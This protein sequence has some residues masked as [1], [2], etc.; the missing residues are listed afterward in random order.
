MEQSSTH[1]LIPRPPVVTVMGH[2]DHG[3][4]TLLDY[5]RKTKVTETEAGGITQHLSAYEVVHTLPDGASRKITFLDTPG[6]EAFQHLRSRGSRVADIAILVVAADDGVKPQTLEALKAIEEACIPFVVAITKIDKNNANIERTK[7]SLL[8]HGVYLEGLGGSVSFVPISSKT[9]E[10][11]STLL[12]LIFLATDIENPTG[13]PTLPASGLVIESHCDPKRGIS[14]VLIIKDGSLHAGEYVIAGNA[15]APLRIIEDFRGK[16]IR[17]A[18]FSSPIMVV[19]FSETPPVGEPFY[20]VLNK[21]EA[22]NIV[23]TSVAETPCG[24]N[25]VESN[26]HTHHF[27]IPVI[28]K[29]DVVGSLEAIKHELHKQE[30]ERMHF[31]II[32]EGV[33]TIG[34][35]DVKLARGD[36]STIIIGFHVDIDPL[37]R[38][39]AERLHI[40]I[41]PF[42]IIYQLADWL[43]SAIAERTPK[44]TGE[45]ELGRA[46]VVKCF[47]K[48]NKTQTIG[49]RIEQG[50]FSVHDRVHLLHQDTVIGN[51]TIN[52]IKS[53]KADAMSMHEGSECGILVDMVTE[54]TAVYGD[55]LVAFVVTE[56]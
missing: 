52:T 25:Q 16:K 42:S 54:H 21:K 47:S 55:T 36:T 26:A 11:I 12:D 20:T 15:S 34:E 44:I 31:N 51:G 10:G 1:H 53:G 3:K 8:E 49:C 45:K 2:I 56:L 41:A 43:P 22:Q 35:S 9:G 4:S 19:G 40:T 7:A 32:H 46:K 37:A 23:K 14:A 30:H 28:I 33:G 6:H 27:S 38:D 39:I 50:V 29:T 17:E 13:D 5:I 24:K 48:T 18:T